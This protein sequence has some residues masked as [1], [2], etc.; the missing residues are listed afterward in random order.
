MANNKACMVV[1]QKNDTSSK[2]IAWHSHEVLE[3]TKLDGS[4]LNVTYKTDSINYQPYIFIDGVKQTGPSIP[5]ADFVNSSKGNCTLNHS[6][7]TPNYSQP[8]T[9]TSTKYM[10]TIVSGDNY[11]LENTELQFDKYIDYIYYSGKNFVTDNM[12]YLGPEHYSSNGLTMYGLDPNYDSWCPCIADNGR[13]C[14]AFDET[15]VPMIKWKLTNYVR[16]SSAIANNDKDFEYTLEYKKIDGLQFEYYTKDDNN[17][18]TIVNKD[19]IYTFDFEPFKNSGETNFACF[20]ICNDPCWTVNWVGGGHGFNA[21]Y[22]KRTPP[23]VGRINEKKIIGDWELNFNDIP[24]YLISFVNISH[25]PEFDNVGWDFHWV[26]GLP[27]IIE[28][29][30]E[31]GN[32]HIRN[33]SVST[34]PTQKKHWYGANQLMVNPSAG[35]SYIQLS[36]VSG[37][38]WGTY[39]D[40]ISQIEYVVYDGVHELDQT[41][42]AESLTC[43]YVAK[44]QPDTTYSLCLFPMI[45]GV[46]HDADGNPVF[47]TDTLQYVLVFRKP[48]S[49]DL[50]YLTPDVSQ[51]ST[52]KRKGNNVTFIIKIDDVEKEFNTTKTIA[53]RYGCEFNDD[54]QTFTS[55]LDIV[56][57]CPY[58]YT[59]TK[60]CI[61][62]IDKDMKNPV[63]FK[64][65][66]RIN[67]AYY[68]GCDFIS[69][70]K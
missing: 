28:Y 33:Y 65:G 15:S 60:D 43:T 70:N 20:G 55:P 24:V 53:K 27:Y 29:D 23:V 68:S 5:I 61:L 14:A 46:Q 13:M 41:K 25:Q 69:Y 22:W 9:D 18:Y 42:I 39:T 45:L 38:K 30:E 58:L 31:V 19:D 11:K 21:D 36:T 4:Q 2:S 32:K 26:T 49:E 62:K 16:T 40:G 10:Y 66:S 34:N 7:Y 56:E 63:I 52:C 3:N 1:Y 12:Y 47:I 57:G 54:N 17:E 6:V 48:T 37:N 44:L 8:S 59:F 51:Q 67:T 64:S 35:S 50:K